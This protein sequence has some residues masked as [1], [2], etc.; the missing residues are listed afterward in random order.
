MNIEKIYLGKTKPE[1]GKS[2]LI[3][4]YDFEWSCG[5]YWSGGSIGNKHFHCHFDDCFLK[6]PDPRGHPLGDFVTPWNATEKATIIH[7]GGS[8]WENLSTF[9]DEP[10]FDQDQWW[11]IK[12][13]FKQFY[14]LRDAAEVFQYG[15]HCTSAGRI[16]K[17]INPDMVKQINLHIQNVIISEIRKIVGFKSEN[18]IMK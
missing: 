10:K 7:N 14:I 15:G 12:D 13:L 16:E 3:F 9:L 1:F 11:R 6:A 2:E 18:P 4:L 8:I 5:W 17:E